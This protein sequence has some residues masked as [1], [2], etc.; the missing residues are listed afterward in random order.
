MGTNICRWF[1]SP[2]D[3][4][5]PTGTQPHQRALFVT[6]AAPDQCGAQ[7]RCNLASSSLFPRSCPS[8]SN[9]RRAST[10]ASCGGRSPSR[11][12]IDFHCRRKSVEETNEIVGR[13]SFCHCRSTRSPSPVVAQRMSR[14]FQPAIRTYHQTSVAFVQQI[15][16]GPE[17]IRGSMTMPFPTQLRANDTGRKCVLGMTAAAPVHRPTDALRSIGVIHILQFLPSWA[18]TSNWSWIV[19][20]KLSVNYFSKWGK[21][22]HSF[23]LRGCATMQLKSFSSIISRAGLIAGAILPVSG[24]VSRA[25]RHRALPPL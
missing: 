14:E 5:H 10:S 17:S 11:Q 15:T 19:R 22:S 6:K 12:D 24:L 4:R 16:N 2:H 18:L 20:N 9:S 23:I 25:P 8:P 3:S 7:E 21:I 1:L 13:A